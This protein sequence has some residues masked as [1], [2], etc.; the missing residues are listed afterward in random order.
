MS[1]SPN[2]FDEAIENWKAEQ[3]L[4]WNR[5]K[6]DLVRANVMRHLG[7]PGGRVLDAGGGNGL[8]SVPLAEQGFEVDIVDSSPAMLAE[9]GRYAAA[10]GVPDR[11]HLHHAGLDEAAAI[12]AGTVFDLV[13]CHNVMQYLPAQR[14]PGALAKL[15]GLLKSGGLVSLVSLNRYSVPYKT[16]FF[17]GDLDKA[18]GQLDTRTV[19]VYLFDATVTC[20]TA[21]EAGDLLRQAGLAVE[22][23]YGIRCV[24]DYWGSNEQKL[25]PEVYGRLARLEGALA[26]RHPY[27]L[28]ARFFQVV[29]R[30][31]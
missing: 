7:R 10:V 9:A 31:P 18:L 13:L 6:Y 22:G 19:K 2:V 3:A 14:V 20:Y 25:D 28:L 16:A 15:T 12:L 26:G 21:E 8:D 11:V 30:K 23:D 24:G 4:P 27:K 1:E 29:A 17:E 5:L